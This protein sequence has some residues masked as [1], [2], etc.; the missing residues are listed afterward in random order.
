[1]KQIDK[2]GKFTG[3]GIYH[4]KVVGRDLVITAS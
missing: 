1:M 3:Q 2:K 4:S